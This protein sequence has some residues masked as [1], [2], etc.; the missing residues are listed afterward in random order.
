MSQRRKY[1]LNSYAVGAAPGCG[2]GW[3]CQKTPVGFN[4]AA[5]VTLQE[6]N[7]FRSINMRCSFHLIR[8]LPE[9]QNRACAGKRFG[10]IDASRRLYLK[11]IKTVNR[12]V[13]MLLEVPWASVSALVP[14]KKIHT[15]QSYRVYQIHSITFP[16]SRGIPIPRPCQ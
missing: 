8:I 2:M 10:W 13:L 12:F 14:Q 5:S 1:S 11:P 7:N 3:S 4:Y 9:D 16:C 15:T 6:K